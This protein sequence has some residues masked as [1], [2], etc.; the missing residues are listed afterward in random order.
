M[1]KSSVLFGKRDSSLSSTRSSEH[2]ESTPS[3][4][5]GRVCS[6]NVYEGSLRNLSH[7]SRGKTE[8]EEHGL[9]GHGL[10]PRDE[11]TGTRIP[12]G[13]YPAGRKGRER[14]TG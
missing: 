1:G 8:D 6:Y 5:P 14:E 3:F 11:E 9:S 2:F 13:D 12:A 10:S 4:L 7:G